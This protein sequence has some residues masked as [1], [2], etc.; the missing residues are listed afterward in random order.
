ME[1]RFAFTARYWGNGAVVC[2]AIEDRP[3]PIVEPQ[4]GEFPTWTQALGFANR[5]NQGSDL[6]L[7]EV[8]QIVTSSL[9]ATA[10][11]LQ[12]AINCRRVWNIVQLETRAAHFRLKRPR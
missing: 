2:R 1:S 9:L 11:V 8:R 12:E 10:S 5:L 6:D 7:L 3:G 4:F